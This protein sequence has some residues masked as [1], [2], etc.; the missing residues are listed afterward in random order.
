MINSKNNKSATLY[1]LSVLFLFFDANFVK[2][3]INKSKKSI[4]FIDNYIT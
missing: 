2:N 4:I 3:I 1:L